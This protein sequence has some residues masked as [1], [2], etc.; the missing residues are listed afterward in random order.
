MDTIIKCEKH[1]QFLE[2]IIKIRRLSQNTKPIY[3]DN[4][5]VILR[6]RALVFLANPIRDKGKTDKMISS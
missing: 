3:D 2:L 1:N 6:F 5:K 4:F